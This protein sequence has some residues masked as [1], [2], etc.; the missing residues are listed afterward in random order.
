MEAQK[1]Q[2]ELMLR[3]KNEEVSCRKLNSDQFP[4]LYL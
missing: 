1:R 2:Q 4:S 3:R